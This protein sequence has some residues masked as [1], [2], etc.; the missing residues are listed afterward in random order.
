MRPLCDIGGALACFADR[1]AEINLQVT[2]VTYA[3]EINDQPCA[4]CKSDAILKGGRVVVFLNG[5]L[6]FTG[7]ACVR[8]ERR[9]RR[10]K[11]GG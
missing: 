3:Q 9:F 11:P 10:P 6:L 2:V 7:A 8:Q 4:I 1:V 5:S